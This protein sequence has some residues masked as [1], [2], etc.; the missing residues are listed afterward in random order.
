MEI[1]KDISE[2]LKA[3]YLDYAMSVIVGRAIPDV[4]DGLKPVQRR[5]LYA[6]YEMGL[7][8]NRPY[9]KSARIVGDV[10]GKYHPH[11]DSAVYDA[12]VRMA[13]DFNMR[14]PLVDGQGN[15]GSI[16]GDEPAAMRYTE[17][18]LTKIAEEMLADIDKETVDFVPNFDATLKE[19]SVLPSKIPNLLANG[20]S[21]IAVGMATNIPPHNLREICDAVIAYIENEEISVEELMNYIK[22]PDFPTGGIIVGRGGIKEA[23]KTGKGKITV[24]GRVEFEDDVIVIR[25]IPYQVNKANLVE[26]IAELAREGKIEEIKAVRDESDREGIRVVIELKSGA[27]ARIVL[28]RLY[29]F[30]QLQ[31]TFGIINL[32]LVDNQ[33]KVLSLK[34]MIAEFVNHRR[35][36]VRRRTE[37]EL[38]KAEERLHI[39]E[40]LKVAVE[41]IDETVELIKSSESPEVAKK[42]LVD[43]FNLTE[44]QAEAILQMRLQRLTALEIDSLLKEYKELKERIEELKS[45]LESKRKID[46]IIIQETREIAEKY[47]EER[48]TKIIDGDDEISESDLFAEEENL[49]I[50]TKGGYA[51]RVDLS[52][53]RTQGRGG[54]GVVGVSLKDDDEICYLGIVNSAYRLILFTNKGK[55]YWIN[56]YEI[57]KLERTARGT[58]L[59]S[60]ISIEQDEYVVGAISSEDFRGEVLILTKDG[61]IK[62]VKL[63]EFENAKRAGIVA[64][65]GEPAIIKKARGKE[66][67][68]STKNGM[69]V[70]FEREEVPVYGRTAKGVKALKLKEGD[71]IAWMDCGSE[72]EILLLSENGY[73]K[74]V[75]TDEFRKISRGGQGVICFRVTEKTGNVVF[76][77]FVRGE[78]VLA[79]SRDG[80]TIV[81]SIKDIS[82][83]GRNTTGVIVARNGIEKA[84]QVE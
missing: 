45:I 46:E 7:L 26:K 44:K 3:S 38:K 84:V 6:M 51:K 50:I 49:L 57:P 11:G 17:A 12:L 30:T 79:V 37:F 56:A 83:Q 33:P 74:R 2:E 61:Y 76:S 54:S 15:F 71:E 67:L 81:V 21:G 60:M 16:D 40:G 62:A 9:R 66:I 10:L 8:S 58:S 70:R 36:V 14:Y 1:M 41:S 55:A 72:K 59:R 35:E 48:R 23:Y 13:Q 69:L 82:Q 4:R 18:R 29:K 68:I 28:N 34:E 19:P 43:R 47:G 53:F 64:V 5:I 75:E 25:E 80:S 63:S 65:N 52:S 73:G 27:N 42:K 20:S 39:V 22:G 77:E 31:T 78:R 32:A 24:R